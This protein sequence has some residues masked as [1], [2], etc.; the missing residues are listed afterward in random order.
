MQNNLLGGE[1]KVRFSL[2]L[3]REVTVGRESLLIIGNQ[4]WMRGPMDGLHGLG[5][6]PSSSEVEP[7][8]TSS[9]L[10]DEVAA[11]AFVWFQ[12]TTTRTS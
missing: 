10:V 6:Q 4:I 3:V 9:P 11:C 8:Q 5:R 7:E 1:T 12:D 2:F